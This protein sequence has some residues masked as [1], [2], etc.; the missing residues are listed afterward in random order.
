MKKGE[1]LLWQNCR[2]RQKE[3]EDFLA[4]NVSDMDKK[5]RS[6]PKQFCTHFFR[7]MPF[8]PYKIPTTRFSSGSGRFS[9]SQHYT[10]FSAPCRFLSNYS[11]RV[12]S[13]ALRQFSHRKINTPFFPPQCRFPLTN[14]PSIFSAQGGFHPINIGGFFSVTCRFLPTKSP[15]QEFC[16]PHRGF[17][18]SN[19]LR[20]FPPQ[21]HF[22]STKTLPFCQARCGISPTIF[23]PF[24]TTRA[25]SSTPNPHQKNFVRP[26]AAFPLST[27]DAFFLHRAA[28]SQQLH[29]LIFPGL[30]RFL[31]PK[32]L[33]AFFP[34]QC[35]LLTTNPLYYFEEF[36]GGK[37]LRMDK[38][39]HRETAPCPPRRNRSW[40]KRN[41]NFL[42]KKGRSCM[43]ENS[44][45]HNKWKADFGGKR[46][47]TSQKERLVERGKG[48]PGRRKHSRVAWRK[49]DTG[50]NKREGRKNGAVS[51]EKGWSWFME[52]SKKQEKDKGRKQ[53]RARPK[54]CTIV[55]GNGT[56]SYEIWRSCSGLN[57]TVPDKKGS[58]FLGEN[59]SITGKKRASLYE[60][61][62]HRAV[63]MTAE[64]F[65]G[66][67]RQSG[68]KRGEVDG[69]KLTTGPTKRDSVGKRHCA[70]QEVTEVGLRKTTIR[71]T[72]WGVVG[73][74]R[75]AQSMTKGEPIFRKN[76]SGRDKKRAWLYGE[77]GTVPW[78][79]RQSC[80][81]EKRNRAEQKG[82]MLIGGNRQPA[83]HKGTALVE[84]KHQKVG[85]WGS[86]FLR[87]NV[88]GA[89]K[90]RE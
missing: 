48:A 66:K 4:E 71:Q 70:G 28:F 79:K 59:D 53:L 90:K 13:T 38:S 76:N 63:Q 18:P 73:C 40:F 25:V 89:H 33:H 27:L 29:H 47:R 19:L 30:M 78:K 37:R 17:F 3:G 75:T 9:S 26:V 14:S 51:D 1:S 64:L 60:G 8:P 52:N 20:F 23:H 58:R 50:E 36:F 22:L 81:A 87:E 55:G 68:T 69:G 12:I 10:L 2:K 56:R 86:R 65:G 74:V 44:K 72:N 7:T 24:Y 16:P 31:S 32:T 43:C 62:G 85:D 80:L 88:S 54:P 82:E 35:H 46:L 83:G 67:T 6:F 45:K 15:P 5:R 49:K 61:K 42:N 77:K 11:T 39:M 41:D 57:V 34:P 21:C 84:E